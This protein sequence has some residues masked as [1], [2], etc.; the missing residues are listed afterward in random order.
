MPATAQENEWRLVRSNDVINIWQSKS[1]ADGISTI[2]AELTTKSTL[3]GFLL[4]LQDTA[5]IPNW[6]DNSDYS[7]IIAQ[8]TPT[9][10]VFITQFEGVWPVK[11]RNMV[12][13]TEYVQNDDFSIDI[14]VQDASTKAEQISDSIRVTV[15]Q[16]HW[17]IKP[18]I[19]SGIQIQY[20]FSVDPNG[21]IPDWLVNKMT[22]DS[23]WKTLNNI[24]QQL[25]SSSWQD[26]SISNIEEPT[27][28][29]SA[30]MR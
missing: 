5:N 27:R 17:H 3:S 8:L 25:P 14:F 16:A 13:E 7:E 15:N 11:S 4:F 29:N 18:I 6:L 24:H 20:Q 10:N 2:K 23:V 22:L 28:E 9:R 26:F 19:D 30:E 1:K 21:A 12:I